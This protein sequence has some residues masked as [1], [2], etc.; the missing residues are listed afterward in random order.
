MAEVKTKMMTDKVD[1]R[2]VTE[3]SHNDKK[4]KEN[5]IA[6]SIFGRFSDFNSA[7]DR[8]YNPNKG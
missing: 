8:S 6:Q 1:P 5:I 2:E 7:E 3:S 4:N